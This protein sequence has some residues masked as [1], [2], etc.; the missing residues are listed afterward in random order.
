[1]D[2]AKLAE[3]VIQDLSRHRSRNDIIMS[4]CQTT[5]MDW[6]QAERFI[7]QVEV[8]Q[9]QVIARRQRPLLVVFALAGILGG[10]VASAGIVL[11]TIDGW[12]ILFLNFPVP[13]LGNI[14]YFA[15]G[16]LGMVGGF[17]G[18]RSAMKDQPSK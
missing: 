12:I 15:L 7:R 5:G 16:V 17:I 4:V 13:Y 10:F 9:G 2:T 11:A 8:N 14:V 6:P 1:M 3:R 18:L